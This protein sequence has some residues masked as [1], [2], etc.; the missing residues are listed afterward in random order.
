[1]KLECSAMALADLDR[2]AAFLHDRDPRLAKIVAGEITR[3]AQVLAEHPE[4]GRTLPPDDAGRIVAPR[5]CGYASPNPTSH[6]TVSHA[7][8]Q[9]PMSLQPSHDPLRH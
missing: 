2:F 4:L 8:P 6:R 1:M 3:K 7:I 5:I 9:I